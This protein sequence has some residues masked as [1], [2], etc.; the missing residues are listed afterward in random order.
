MLIGLEAV[1]V[2]TGQAYRVHLSLSNSHQQ[3]SAY[4][5]HRPSKSAEDFKLFGGNKQALLFPQALTPVIYNSAQRACH[6]CHSPAEAPRPVAGL[7]LNGLCSQEFKM[8]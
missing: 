6:A 3:C 2:L 4:T 8:D 5:S 1:M 7:H